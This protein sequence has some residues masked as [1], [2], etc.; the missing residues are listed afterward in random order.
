CRFHAAWSAALLGDKTSLPL[1]QTIAVNYAHYRDEAVI[2]AFRMMKH[3]I[4]SEGVRATYFIK[5]EL[6]FE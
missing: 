3:R 5:S 1:L 4:K 6:R 2:T